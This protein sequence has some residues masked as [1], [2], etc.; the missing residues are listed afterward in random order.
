MGLSN[1]H[2]HTCF[3]DGKN[4]PEEMVLKALE[5][6]MSEL[7]FSG[8]SFTEFDG[9]YCMTLENTEKYIDTVSKLKQQYKDSISIKLGIE[10]DYFS[11]EKTDRYE[12]VIGSVHYVKKDGHYL[13]IDKSEANFIDSVNTYYGGDYYAFCEDY[14]ALVGDVYCRTK[15]DIV[16]HFDLVTKFNEGGKLFDEKNERYVKAYRAALD[17]LLP[18]GVTFE[19][20]YGAIARGYRTTPYPNP[21]ILALIREHGNPIIRTSDCH[22]KEFL[23]LGITED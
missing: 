21:D 5:G 22:N 20:N 16:G 19:V 23:L 7:G 3:C 12:Y 13:P 17:K 4:S 2:T 6:G 14:Y 15:C 1:L 10:Q 9:S 8:H 11:E 18:T